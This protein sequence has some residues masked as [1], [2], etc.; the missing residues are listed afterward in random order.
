MRHYTFGADPEIFLINL[1]TGEPV[2]AHGIIPG[3][4]QNPEPFS[5][6]MIQL[7]GTAAEFNILPCETEDEFVSSLFKMVRDVE[8]FV[9]TKNQ[10]LGVIIAPSVHYDPDYFKKIPIS[11]RRLGCDPD[12]DAYSMQTNT[13]PNPRGTMRTGAG[14]IHIGWTVGEYPFAPLHFDECARITRQLDHSLLIASMV[15]WD[16]DLERRKMYGRAGSFRPKHFGVEYRPLSN[17]YLQN[18]SD[19]RC[20]F[21]ITHKA[22]ELFDDGVF[23]FEDG[24]LASSLMQTNFGRT[25]DEEACLIALDHLRKKYGFTEF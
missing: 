11:S 13:P 9:K 20:V 14:H 22:L 2:S 8:H 15:L 25:H 6:G 7:D 17:A 1:M 12:F 16:K 3:N 18:E 19:T 4:K 5:V 10:E 24:L 21:R 23:L